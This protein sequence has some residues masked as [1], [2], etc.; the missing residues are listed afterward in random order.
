M[1]TIG[2]AHAD[3]RPRPADSP[4]TDVGRKRFSEGVVALKGSRYEEARISFQQ[5]YALKP[6]PATLRNLA[7]AELKTGRYPEAARHFTTYLETTPLSEID[8]VDLVRQALADARLHCGMLV[9]ETDVS[10]AEIGVDGE[11]IGRTP[12]GRDPWFV[13]PGEHVVTVRREGYDDHRERQRL[14]AGRTMRVLVTLQPS[15]VAA[16]S[17][18]ALE[19]T[20]LAAAERLASSPVGRTIEPGEEAG[21]LQPSQASADHPARVGVAPLVVGGVITIAGLAV[22]I[23]YSVASNANGRDRDALLASIPGTSPKCGSGTPYGDSCEQVQNLA[24]KV[25]AQRKLATGGFVVAGV[26]GAATLVYWLW[27]RGSRSQGM[28]VPSFSPAY[29]GIQW[30]SSF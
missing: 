11:T 26:A 30:R 17:G 4:D 2:L 18:V 24:D 23:G 12:L 15:G 7:A 1:M 16:R 20:A 13:D 19:T 22:G 6:A 10:G 25:D 3:P 28:V 21:A 5:S 27:P 14:E 8:R 29:A 9:V